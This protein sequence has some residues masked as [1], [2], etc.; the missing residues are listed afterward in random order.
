MPYGLLVRPYPLYLD[1]QDEKY[2]SPVDSG[3]LQRI[4]AKGNELREKSK[5]TASPAKLDPGKQMAYEEIN[6]ATHSFSERNKLGTGGFGSVFSGQ[7]R[8]GTQVAPVIYAS[9]AYTF[10]LAAVC[11]DCSKAARAG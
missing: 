11:A 5:V 6:E 4:R 1:P 2:S 3:K 10:I 9:H 8:S 7:L